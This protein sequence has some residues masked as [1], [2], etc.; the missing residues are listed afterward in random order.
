MSMIE[1]LTLMLALIYGTSLLYWS[2]KKWGAIASTAT[3]LS[4][5]LST[6]YWPLFLCL[7]LAAVTIGVLGRLRPQWVNGELRINTQREV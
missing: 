7:V 3:L 5:T 1:S 6:L 2:G 4:A